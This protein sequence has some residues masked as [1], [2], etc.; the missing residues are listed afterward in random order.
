MIDRKAVEALD[1]ADPLAPWRERFHLPQGLIYLDGN[2][3]GAMPRS[4][5]PRMQRA[6]EREWAE[7]LIGSWNDAGWFD[8]PKR[9]GAKISR[10]VG[11]EDDEMIV[12]D[13]TSVDLFKLLVAAIRLRPGRSRIVGVAGD[14]PTDGYVAQGV[15]DLAKAE[16]VAVEPDRLGEA[17][18]ER[19]AVLLLTQVNYKTGFLYDME[20]IT[21]LA[22]RAGA[23]A[24]WDL[25]HSAGAMPIALDAARADFAVGCG[26]KYLNG[27]P[28][29]PAFVYVARRH[30]ADIRQPIA[31]WIGH[32][33]PFDFAAD[34]EAAPDIRRML[35]G[36]PP[37]L[38][39]VALEAAIEA[40]DG[41][42]MATMRAK[43]VALTDL[44]IR[45]IDQEVEGF[46]L[47]TPRDPAQRGS[48]V[49]LTHPAGYRV[50][51]AL[52]AR[53]VIGDFRAPDI[54]RFGFAP[55]YQR[56]VQVWDAVA[57]LKE[58]MA[59]G[60]WKRPEFAERKAVT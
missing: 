45:L 34:Y 4:V 13:S 22:H 33:R 26:Y 47:A 25:C 12:A 18:D 44:F 20:K 14:F 32:A 3:L 10:L 5:V 41:I 21:R 59:S 42:D 53:G 36:T 58:V 1:A 17:L 57:A 16:F 56:Y 35:S 37:V 8:A 7:G 23:L 28:G 43:S 15:A 48:Q 6:L 19:A 39:L 51:Q 38:G 27:G 29:A 54:L 2:S 11:A 49:S 60:V 30:L 40:F 24:I 52:I 50:M 46:G 31:G 9:I 55:L